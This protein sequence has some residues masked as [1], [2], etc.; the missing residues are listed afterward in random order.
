MLYKMQ[1]YDARSFLL[2]IDSYENEVPIG[3]YYNP[4]REEGGSFRSMVQMLLK[5]EHCM[6]AEN[7][8]QSFQKVRT[9]VPVFGYWGENSGNINPVM[10]RK[11][12]FALHILFRQNASWQGTLVWLEEK[13]TMSFR[14]VLELITLLNSALCKG[15]IPAI[16]SFDAEEIAE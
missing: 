4:S 16:P 6:D 12:T 9:F 13:K 15:E 2:Y 5:L 14:S 7:M 10:G 3:R 11:A 1:R 8:P